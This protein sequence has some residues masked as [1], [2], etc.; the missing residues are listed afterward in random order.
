MAYKLEISKA[1]QADLSKLDKPVLQAIRLRLT[2]L[3]ENAEQ[4]RHLP[5][6]GKLSGLYKLRVYE[7][8]RVIYD[9]QR[10]NQLIV[11]VRVGNR[12]DIYKE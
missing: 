1:A 4:I 8:Y 12:D 9:L 3:A 5:L 7:K 10:T 2:S 6:K 11:V